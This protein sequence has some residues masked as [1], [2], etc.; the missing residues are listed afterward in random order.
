MFEED[1]SIAK[2]TDMT[3]KEKIF[4]NMKEMKS[5]IKQNKLEK[6]EN[7]EKYR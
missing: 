6:G 7:D 4:S 2:K 1:D 3:L 5:R